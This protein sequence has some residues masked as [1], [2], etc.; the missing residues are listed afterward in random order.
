MKKIDINYSSTKKVLNGKKAVTIVELIVVITILAILGTVSFLGFQ[1]YTVY[2]R[3]TVRLTDLKNIKSVLEYTYTESW[4]YVLP[5]NWTGVTFSWGLVWTQWIFWKETRRATKRLN[6][7]PVDPLTKNHYTYSVLNKWDQYELGAIMEWWEISKSLLED[8]YADS[9]LKWFIT[10]NYNWKIAKVQIDEVEYVLAVPSIINWD[11]SYETLEDIVSNQTFSM[12]WYSNIP[13]SYNTNNPN[14][15]IFVNSGSLVVFSGS[16]EDLE[17]SDEQSKFLTNLKN[18][19]TSTDIADSSNISDIINVTE[20]SE[21]F[22][23]QT[24]INSE[25]N[26][27]VPI[28]SSAPEIEPEPEASNCSFPFNLWS[29][30]LD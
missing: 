4:K 8:S 9:W 21:E 15:L 1:S 24:L 2:S 22:L 26:D 12:N 7:A 23:T 28:L 3:D 11:M 5:E 25:V 6:N 20:N 17:D 10:W 14:N 29:C 16:T 27:D 18:A 30:L 19:Y 13:D